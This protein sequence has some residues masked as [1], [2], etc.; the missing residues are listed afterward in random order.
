MNWYIFN[1]KGNTKNKIKTV[2][3]FN[4]ILKI[5]AQSVDLSYNDIGELI[6]LK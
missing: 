5:S 6:T 1:R 2:Y 4:Q 3:I